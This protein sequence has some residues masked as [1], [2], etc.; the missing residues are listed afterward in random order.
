MT[1]GT[2]FFLA[3]TE[4]RGGGIRGG[5]RVSASM[6]PVGRS[7]LIRDGGRGRGGW[8]SKNTLAFDESKLQWTPPNPSGVTRKSR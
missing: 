7:S 8:Q 4:R 1:V 6:P 3:W 5:G 2:P